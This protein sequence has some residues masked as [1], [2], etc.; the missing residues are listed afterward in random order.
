MESLEEKAGKGAIV[1]VAATASIT[2]GE[3]LIPNGGF[4]LNQAPL[5]RQ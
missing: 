2:T 1:N 4:H 3:T 5:I